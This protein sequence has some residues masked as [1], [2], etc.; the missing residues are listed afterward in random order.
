MTCFARIPAGAARLLPD[1]KAAAGAS[2]M[3][4][5]L[6]PSQRPAFLNND[7]AILVPG[8]GWILDCAGQGRGVD[9]NAF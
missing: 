5:S 4:A 9:N 6:E 2:C 8:V 1:E 3:A 7:V